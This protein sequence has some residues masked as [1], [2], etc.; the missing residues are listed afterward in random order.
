MERSYR[1]DRYQ[2]RGETDGSSSGEENWLRVCLF[3]NG[4]SS[5]ASQNK[6]SGYPDL[7]DI[8]TIFV[9]DYAR[10]IGMIAGGTRVKLHRLPRNS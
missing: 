5:R 2:T 7:L 1:I 8:R 3:E 4:L 9:P 10:S 6:I